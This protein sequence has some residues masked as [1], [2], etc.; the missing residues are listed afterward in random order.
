M[1]NKKVVH[2]EY[3]DT[4]TESITC[5]V[6]GKTYPG[7]H[8]GRASS[9]EVLETEVKLRTGSAYPEGGMGEVVFF[10]ICPECFAEFLIP[11]LAKHGVHPTTEDW[12]W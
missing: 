10:D 5:D 9:Y 2:K 1:R 7:I 8:W 3:D 4:I 12:D 6:C 11:L